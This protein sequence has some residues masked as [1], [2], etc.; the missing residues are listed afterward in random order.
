MK[1]AF[2]PAP[3]SMAAPRESAILCHKM[4]NGQRRSRQRLGLR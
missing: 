2:W 4:T 1:S 3:K